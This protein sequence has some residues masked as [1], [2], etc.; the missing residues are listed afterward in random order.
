MSRTVVSKLLKGLFNIPGGS[1]SH[2]D[3]WGWAGVQPSLW[4]AAPNRLLC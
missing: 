1:T 4:T 3:G 2:L